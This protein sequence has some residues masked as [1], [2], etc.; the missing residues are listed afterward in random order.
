MD[1]LRM[2]CYSCYMSR[3][4]AHRELRNESSRV[5]REVEDGETFTVTNRGRPVAMLSPVSEEGTRLTLRARR[6]S[7]SGGFASIPSVESD[8][9]SGEILEDLRGAR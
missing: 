9:S 1:A 2:E 6:A 4:I 7:V 3:E 5:L 8:W